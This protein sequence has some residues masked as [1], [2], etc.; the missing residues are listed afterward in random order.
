MRAILFLHGLLGSPLEFRSIPVFLK[1]YYDKVVMIT[2]PGHGETPKEWANFKAF[3]TCEK[4]LNCFEYL[5][6]MYDEIDVVGFSMGGTLASYLSSKYKVRRVVLLSPALK[7][8]SI[9]INNYRNFLP[10]KKTRKKIEGVSFQEIRKK[11]FHLNFPKVIKQFVI[12]NK[13]CVGNIKSIPCPML[14]IWGKY[15]KIVPYQAVEFAYQLCTNSNKH[16]YV[17]EATH[18]IINDENEKRITKI[19]SKFLN[20]N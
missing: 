2:Y 18:R 16:V 5:C 1:Q 11:F 8:L 19:I 9:D 7:Y 20:E 12:L 6:K 10:D 3:E 17:E 13:A 15:D 4:V 14:I